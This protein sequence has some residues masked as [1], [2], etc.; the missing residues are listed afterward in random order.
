MQKKILLTSQVCKPVA[1]MN[2]S[3][4]IYVNY[5]K[6]KIEDM[7]EPEA[8]AFWINCFNMMAMHTFMEFGACDCIFQRLRL[9]IRGQYEIGGYNFRAADIFFAILRNKSPSISY[10]FA[11]KTIPRQLEP[12]LGDKDSRKRFTFEKP[13]PLLV[14]TINIALKNSPTLRVYYPATVYEQIENATK[15]YLQE[16]CKFKL[17]QK[18]IML[19]EYIL[20][21]PKDFGKNNYERVTFLVNYMPQI[22]PFVANLIEKKQL[23]VKTEKF[24]SE[25]N[26]NHTHLIKQRDIALKNIVH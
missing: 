11:G 1:N 2:N 6:L 25:F 19:P 20:M 4:L 15:E 22:Q 16:Y 12:R 14:F 18:E 17:E 23:T 7:P 13:L 3:N 9:L 10:P 5:K 8:L 26:Y 21:F 24:H